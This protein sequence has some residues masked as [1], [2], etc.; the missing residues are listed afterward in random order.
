MPDE[1]DLQYRKRLQ[2][3]ADEY[4]WNEMRAMREEIDA[5]HIERY[6]PSFQKKLADAGLVGLTWPEPHGRGAPVDQQFLMAEELECQGF[7]GYGLTTNLRGGGMLLR[8]GSDEQIATH[9]PHVVDGSWTYCQGLSEPGAGSDLLSLKTKAVRDGDHF[10]INGAKL[11]TSSAHISKWCSLLVRTDAT[12]SRHRGLSLLL[13]DLKSPGVTIQPVWVMGGWRVNAVFYD[14]VRVPVSNLVGTEHEGWKVITGNL[15]E[16]RAMSFGGT[17]TRLLCARLIHRLSARRETLHD[18]DLEMLGRFVMELEADRL[19]YL[20]VG[21]AAARGEDTSGIGPMSKVYGSEL[22][23]RFIEWA[24]ELLGHETLFSESDDVL[25]RD[26]EQQL[27]VAT[28]LT[29]I[30]GTS[31][32]QRNIVANRHLGLPRSN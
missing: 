12:Q 26:M 4:G 28:V 2:S 8:N 17:E 23:Q 14:D 32:V 25:A 31:E 24:C 13:V 7:P 6:S 21:L 30:G 16:E 22:A 27:R 1:S 3:L 15:D 19:L 20:R 10:V 29:V 18:S 11:W 5:L 9:L